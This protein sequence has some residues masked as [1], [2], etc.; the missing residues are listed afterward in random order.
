M[1][2]SRQLVQHQL[3]VVDQDRSQRFHPLDRLAA[4]DR[5][6]QLP[7][8]RV[9]AEQL[10]RP[11][12]D[13]VGEQQLAARWRPQT[14]L[15]Q[16][17]RTLVGDLEVADLLDLVAPE[18]DPE[19]MLLGRRED[20]EDSA[21]HREVASLLDEVRAGVAGCDEV[22]HDVGELAPGVADLQ[23]H[24]H[25]LAQTRNLRLQHRSD[26]RDDDI[27]WPRGRVVRLG[28]SQPA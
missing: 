11:G 5:V 28:V 22:G 8:L 26:R 10:G 6:E 4:T 25:E 20:V 15:G 21:A 12:L 7:E 2:A 17:D 14:M 18:L 1:G 27:E 19:R 24:R 3:Q 16:L 23:R 13:V 9:L